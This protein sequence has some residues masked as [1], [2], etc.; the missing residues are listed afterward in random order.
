MSG[1]VDVVP[2]T[3]L[4]ESAFA[5]SSYSNYCNNDVVSAEVTGQHIANQAI[6]ER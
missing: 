6:I 4:N 5:S 1:Y 3:L 2:K